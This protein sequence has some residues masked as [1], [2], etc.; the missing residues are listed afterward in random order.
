MA[1]TL[2]SCARP[3][4]QQGADAGRGKVER[5]VM[6]WMALHK[7][8]EN[9][10]DYDRAAPIS[11]ANSRERC[12]EGLRI[13]LEGGWRARGAC[14]SPSRCAGWRRPLAQGTPGFR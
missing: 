3:S 8:A 2:R 10:V 14:L 13:A 11:S 4:E 6:G 5:I 7:D 1:I 12:L 9:D